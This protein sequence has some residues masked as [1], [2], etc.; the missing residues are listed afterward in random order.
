MVSL[1]LGVRFRNFIPAK[2][3]YCDSGVGLHCTT[4]PVILIQSWQMEGIFTFKCSISPIPK[5]FFVIILIPPAL[6]SLIKL[7]CQMVFRLDVS[8]YWTIR[9]LRIRLFCLFSIHKLVAPHFDDWH[10]RDDYF[11]SSIFLPALCWRIT[12]HR[13]KFTVGVY[14]EAW[15][16]KAIIFHKVI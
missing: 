15:W 16:A 7:F 4:L 11:Y 14:G 6:I 12:A 2:N 9:L 1:F 8:R 10:G 5:Y 3:M 13:L